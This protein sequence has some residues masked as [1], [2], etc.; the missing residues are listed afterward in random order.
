MAKEQDVSDLLKG[1][2]N[3]GLHS[4]PSKEKQVLEPHDRT[5]ER[6]KDRDD[7]DPWKLL[8]KMKQE[9]EQLKREKEEETKRAETFKR[10]KEE[11][12]K[13]AAEADKKAA[14]AIEKAVEADKK[15]AEAIEKAAGRRIRTKK[16]DTNGV[17]SPSCP[18]SSS[19]HASDL[20]SR[21]PERG[22]KVSPGR[23]LCYVSTVYDSSPPLPGTPRQWRI[24][25]QRKGNAPGISKRSTRCADHGSN[26]GGQ[27]Q[28][29][30]RGSCGLERSENAR[31]SEVAN[32]AYKFKQL[33]GKSHGKLPQIVC[34]KGW[35][36][37]CRI[38]MPGTGHAVLQ[39]IPIRGRLCIHVSGSA[40]R[41]PLVSLSKPLS[42]LVS[43]ALILGGR[44]G[45]SFS[46]FVFFLSVASIRFKRE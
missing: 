37:R 18:L 36:Q 28:R 7:D 12:T 3:I 24:Q 41:S 27:E 33:S 39:P 29:K 8:E 19:G 35:K 16:S 10:E 43:R 26:E 44:K 21:P 14:E 25:L 13:R 42:S 40:G 38:Q 32:G 20:G 15:A 1:V 4:P 6:S 34:R 9:N 22:R 5:E 46:S 23:L 11:E 31:K 30:R 2:E 17:P 45:S